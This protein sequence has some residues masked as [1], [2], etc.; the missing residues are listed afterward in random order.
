M[1]NAIF[2]AKILGPLYLV[3]SLSF[4]LRSK[5]LLKIYHESVKSPA[6]MYMGGFVSLVLG[7]LLVNAYN[8]WAADW[9]VIVTVM[10]WAALLKGLMLIFIPET[11]VKW[12]DAFLKNK[13]ILR[14]SMGL[15]LLLGIYLTYMAYR[16]A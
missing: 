12:S 2:I 5:D 14:G 4:L 15:V 11:G 7:L 10:G 9:T 3:A 16:V 13:S 6:I 8:V 1:A